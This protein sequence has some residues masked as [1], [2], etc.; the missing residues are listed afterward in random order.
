MPKARGQAPRALTTHND[1]EPTMSLTP[2]AEVRAAYERAMK[3]VPDHDAAVASVAQALCLD[4]EAVE[5]ALAVE[6]A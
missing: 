1:R 5:A 3:L 6:P 2:I 4:I